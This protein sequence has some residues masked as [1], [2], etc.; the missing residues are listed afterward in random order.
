MYLEIAPNASLVLHNAWQ[1]GFNISLDSYESHVRGV[2][3]L[4]DLCFHSAHHAEIFLLSSIAGVMNW[5]ANHSGP[6]PEEIFTDHTV[7][8]PMGYAE[9]KHISERRLALASEKSAIPASVCRMGQIAGPVHDV[10]GMWN[11]QE[12]LPSLC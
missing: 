1:V 7:A 5:S 9:S 4:L 8:Q 10:K 3:H 11:K 6:V 12:W 2:R